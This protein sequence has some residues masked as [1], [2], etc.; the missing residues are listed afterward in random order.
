MKRTI[1]LNSPP[2][3][4]KWEKASEEVF[5]IIKKMKLEVGGSYL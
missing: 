1:L 4:G 5:S 2:E 3:K